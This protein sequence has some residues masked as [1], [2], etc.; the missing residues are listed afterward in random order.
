MK[1]SKIL[2]VRVDRIGDL[3]LTLPVDQLEPLNGASVDWAL[4]RGLGVYAEYAVPAR[5]HFE[6][7]RD[8]SVSGFFAFFK[9]LRAARYDGAFVF[10]APWWVSA[11]LWLARVPLRV[12]PK[13][14]WHSFLFLNRAI[15]Q[16][17]SQAEAHELEYNV[18]LVLEGLGRASAP[19]VLPKLKLAAP[20]AAAVLTRFGL[21]KGGY[22]VVHPGMGGSARNWPSEY[23]VEWIRQLALESKVVVTGT[24]GDRAWLDPVKKALGTMTSISWLDGQLDTKQWLA[25]LGGARAVLAPSTGT[26]HAAA[27]LGVPSIGIY[28]PVRVQAPK[29]WGPVGDF[30]K[31]LVPE[32]NCPGHFECLMEKC[33]HFD[34]MKTLTPDFVVRETKR[35]A[36]RGAGG[37]PDAR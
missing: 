10:H 11:A 13:S 19:P 1:L 14:Q 26:I 30:A 28:S 29:R 2:F 5:S 9:R 8:F 15:R 6:I 32:V 24:A 37:E 34:C 12:G 25:I 33:P 23:Y 20:E 35:L 27:S 17:R 21:S 7:E 4:T 18:K 3:I 16:K 22:Y 31:A 36:S